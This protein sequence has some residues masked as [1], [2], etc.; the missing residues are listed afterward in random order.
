MSCIRL[1]AS[2]IGPRALPDLISR[3]IV[4][5]FSPSFAYFRDVIEEV[6]DPG[7]PSGYWNYIMPEMEHLEKKWMEE[8]DKVA[9][10][11]VIPTSP[12]KS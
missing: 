11:K 5:D 10:A 4:A 7:I 3:A 9:G 1:N 12:P 2:T 6:Q 8:R